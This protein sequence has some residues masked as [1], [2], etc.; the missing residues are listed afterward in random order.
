[1]YADRVTF[2]AG[3]RYRHKAKPE[4]GVGR[5]VGQTTEGKVLIKFEGRPGDVLMQAAFAESHLVADTSTDWQS[6]RRMHRPETV[7]RRVPCGNCATDLRESLTS[8]DGAWKSCPECSA[9]NGRQHVF[10]PN[11]EAFEPPTDDEA[12]RDWC[13]ACRSGDT[14]ARNRTR[15]C[16][17]TARA[18]VEA[19]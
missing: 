13:H 9:R 19:P 1:M 3:E 17:E 8:A 2:Q 12:T 16:R 10:L 14:R 18:P 11:P 5:I 7:V 4:W 6:M 15:V